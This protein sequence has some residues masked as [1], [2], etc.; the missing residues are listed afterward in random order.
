MGSVHGTHLHAQATEEIKAN[1][2]C[3]AVPLY[4]IRHFPMT[5]SDEKKQLRAHARARR[6][7]A[8]ETA[9][10]TAGASVKDHFLAA[11]DALGVDVAGLTVAAYWPM[12]A[13]IDVRP[14]LDHLYGAGAVCA[15]PVVAGR[16]T[17]LVFRRWRPGLDL[18]GGA[19]GTRHPDPAAP[20]VIPDVV[21]TPLLAF[22]HAGER[23][24]QGG[25]Y[26]DRTLEALRKE[27]SV[28][29][30]G[31]AYAAQR[32]DRLPHSVHDQRLDWIVTEEGA[33]QFQ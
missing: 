32:V 12:G 11:L 6:R 20:E 8:H 15:L 28:L 26:Y 25:G 17:R 1:G 21:L 16:D 9:T 14:L 27:G 30:M 18:E 13:E 5:L 24:G 31:I 3:G 22:D 33:I 23:L 10:D 19:L 4:S 29:A 7:A 2:R